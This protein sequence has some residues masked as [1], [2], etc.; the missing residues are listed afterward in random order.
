MEKKMRVYLIK[1][2][3]TIMFRQFTPSPAGFVHEKAVK[4]YCKMNNSTHP[5]I[6]YAYDEVEISER[7][8]LKS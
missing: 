1:A 3:D 5:D 4:D 2:F 8:S 7:E 6:I